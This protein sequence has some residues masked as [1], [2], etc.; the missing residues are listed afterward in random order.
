M[1]RSTLNTAY[2]FLAG[3]VLLAFAAVI[4]LFQ[5]LLG[6]ISAARAEVAEATVRL[7]ERNTFLNNLDR[8]QVT[9]RS[10]ETN[11]RMLTVALPSDEAFEDLTRVLHRAAIAAG[12]ALT[13]VSSTTAEAQRNSAIRRSQGDKTAV[14]ASLTELSANLKFRGSYQQTRVFLEQ[15]ERAPRFIAVDTLKLQRD[16]AVL[17]QLTVELSLRFYREGGKE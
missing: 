10:Q 14:P 9:L 13:D 8:K 16:E 11:E 5:P 6:E 2:L 3:A 7:E 15:L 4:L 12:G 17:D 1:I